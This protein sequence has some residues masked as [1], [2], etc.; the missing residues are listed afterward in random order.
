MCWCASLYEKHFKSQHLLIISIVIMRTNFILL[1]KNKNLCRQIH[2]YSL[3]Y[4]YGRLIFNSSL[5]NY[6]ICYTHFWSV[7]FYVLYMT[8]C[9]HC[10]LL[11]TG[12]NHHQHNI[13]AHHTHS[14]DMHDMYVSI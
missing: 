7:C 8:I 12:H 1:Q 4:P 11:N 3:K 13:L 2:T 6:H 5:T 10:G 14:F 9:R